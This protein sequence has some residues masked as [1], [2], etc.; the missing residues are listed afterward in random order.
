MCRLGPFLPFDSSFA[1]ANTTAGR[2]CDKLE[3]IGASA[4]VS[5]VVTP[6]GSA[7]FRVSILLRPARAA[8]TGSE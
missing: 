1:R 8:W 4:K 7:A 6:G 3:L 2:C 5:V